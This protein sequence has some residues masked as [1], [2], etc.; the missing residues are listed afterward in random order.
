VRKFV[1]DIKDEH[2]PRK[3]ENRQLRRTC[4]NGSGRDRR[5]E[6]MA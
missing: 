6:K 3:F 1:F 2:R 4:V 5:M